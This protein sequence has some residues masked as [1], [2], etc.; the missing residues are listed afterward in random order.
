M[1][2]ITANVLQIQVT[3]MASAIEPLA[4]RKMIFTLSCS[5]LFPIGALTALCDL[6]L[7]YLNQAGQIAALKL[8]PP[9][10]LLAEL[11]G[12]GMTKGLTRLSIYKAIFRTWL[13]IVI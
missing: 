10:C 11:S 9:D 3:K 1:Q 2:V 4:H 13:L 5:N 8:A 7:V 12:L 6:L